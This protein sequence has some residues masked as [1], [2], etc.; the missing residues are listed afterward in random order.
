MLY[1]IQQAVAEIGAKRVAIDSLA[2][3]EVAL[4]P[5]FREEFREGLYHLVE[6]LVGEGITVMP[7]IEVVEAYHE[8]RISPQHPVSFA[9]DD[10]IL[11]RYVEI[12]GA[13][14]KIIAVVKMRN[15]QH[16]KEF[17]EYDVT[18][19]GLVIGEPMQ[20]YRGL[21]HGVPTRTPEVPRSGRR[22]SPAPG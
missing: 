22:R 3:L 14:R 2:G 5:T 15:S 11:Q 10:I 16:R 8:F 12:D 20:Q 21:L 13:I 9:V 19:D 17:R 1:E 4:A 6:T 7:T 18:G